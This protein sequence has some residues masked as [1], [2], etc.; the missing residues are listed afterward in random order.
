MRPQDISVMWSKPSRPLR[1]INA[2]KSVMFLT[3]PL[4]MSP[5]VISARSFWRRSLRSCSIISRRDDVDLRGREEGL[6]SNVHQQTA[7]DHGF[8]FAL[9]GRTFVGDLKDLVPI[10]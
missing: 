6:H 4:R 9:H 7:F 3:V 10:L 2:P 1:S 8:D 5:G